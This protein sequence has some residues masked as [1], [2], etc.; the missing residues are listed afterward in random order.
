[1]IVHRVKASKRTRSFRKLVNYI[2]DLPNGGAK[3]LGEWASNFSTD[4]MDL[5]TLEGSNTQERNQRTTNDKTYHLVVSFQKGENPSR[6]TI[7]AIEQELCRA[8]DTGNTT[9]SQRF[10]TI[11]RTFTSML[12]FLRS[13]L[14]RSTVSS[15]TMTRKSFKKPRLSSKKSTVLDPR[16]IAE[17][18]K[19]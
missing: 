14:S 16:L 1:M 17:K 7:R 4:D 2:R 9:E 6:G 3:V 5:S 10:T 8:S 18:L 11:R 19:K 15:P 12:Q 13:I